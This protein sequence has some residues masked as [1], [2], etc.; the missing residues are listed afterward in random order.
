MGGSKVEDTPPEGNNSNTHVRWLPQLEGE[1]NAILI[2]HYLKKIIDLVWAC[3]LEMLEI[4][5]LRP[6]LQDIM[7]C[8]LRMK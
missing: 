5:F 7:G 4:I 8:H 6:K 1:V 2:L 3:V